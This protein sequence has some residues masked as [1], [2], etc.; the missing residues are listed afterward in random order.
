MLDGQPFTGG[1]W[2][3]SQFVNTRE[4][5]RFCSLIWDDEQTA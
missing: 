1:G 5:W 2:K 3:S 4:G